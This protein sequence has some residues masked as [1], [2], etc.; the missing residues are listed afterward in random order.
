MT[1]QNVLEQANA[2]ISRLVAASWRERDAIK[3]EL[4]AFAQ[5]HEENRELQPHLEDGMKGL[6]LEVRW[7]I[8]E[9]LE[10]LRPPVEEAVDDADEPEEQVAPDAMQIIYDDPRGL[11][12]Q[13]SG[14]RSRYLVTQRDPYTGQP[15]TVEIPAAQ[16]DQIKTQLRGSPYW[17]LGSGEGT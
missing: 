2:I 3:D 13:R 4:L 5:K 11:V 8:E 17:V 10:A 15:Q 12:I 6:P 16:Y 14:D 1:T 7:E 9:V